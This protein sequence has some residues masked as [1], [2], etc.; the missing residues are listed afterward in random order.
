MSN[1]MKFL[2]RLLGP[3]LPDWG[4]PEDVRK[5]VLL[6]VPA[7]DVIANR[8]ETGIDNRMVETL[9]RI[10]SSQELWLEFYG[11]FVVDDAGSFVSM[12]TAG[13]PAVVRLSADIGAEHGVVAALADKIAELAADAD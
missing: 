3:M 2:A 4:E 8:T 7:L 6:V 12:A 10:A 11:L 5:F 1:F 13:D 9:E